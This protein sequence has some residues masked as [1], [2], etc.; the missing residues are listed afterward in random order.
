MAQKDQESKGTPERFPVTSPGVPGTG[1]HSGL[2]LTT[3]MEL[4]RSVGGLIQAVETMTARIDEQ[5]KKLDSMSHRMYAA[6][7]VILLV[8]GGLGWALNKIWDIALKS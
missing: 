4:Q 6:G 7:V 1:E 2:I 8:L 3:V 5:G